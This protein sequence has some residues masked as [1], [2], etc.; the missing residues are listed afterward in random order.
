MPGKFLWNLS[1]WAVLAC[2]KGIYC[3]FVKLHI[4]RTLFIRHTWHELASPRLYKVN[5]FLA[6]ILE[7]TNRSFCTHSNEAIEM[8]VEHIHSTHQFYKQLNQ[9]QIGRIE[10]ESSFLT[11]HVLFNRVPLFISCTLYIKHKIDLWWYPLSLCAASWKDIVLEILASFFQR[12]C[13]IFFALNCDS[14][15]MS[16]ACDVL[17]K[18]T[19]F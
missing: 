6:E 19:V 15:G 3:S 16:F 13:F 2:D 7:L 5:R 14:S 18:Y 1:S 17:L 4:D 9:H 11:A 12:N 10:K 8:L